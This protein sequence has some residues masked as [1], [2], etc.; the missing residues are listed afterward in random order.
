MGIKGIDMA[1]GLEGVNNDEEVYNEILQI[2]YEDGIEMLDTLRQN[3][4]N[5]D[6]K[7]F[8]THTHAMKSASKGIGANDVS[9]RFKEMEFA[10]KDGDMEKIEEKFPSCLSAFEELLGN[11][12]KYLDGDASADG[13]DAVTASLK[14]MKAALEDM[15]TDVFEGILQ[16]MEEQESDGKLLAKLHEIH[17]AYDD[18]DFAQTIAI[19]DEML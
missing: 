8:I 1:A 19:I 16:S 3:L 18:F 11:V 5:T 4:Q 9:E 14:K 7:L 13:E 2:Y 6:L 15:D 10:G 12:K 17:M